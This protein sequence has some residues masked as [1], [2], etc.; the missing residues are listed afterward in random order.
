MREI[1]DDFD[2]ICVADGPRISLAL[3]CHMLVAQKTCPAAKYHVA[4]PKD[5]GFQHE[6][7]ERVITSLAT[8]IYEI[9]APT[10]IIDGKLYRL[11][12]KINAMKFYKASPAILID[13][14]LLF[15]R[16]LPANYAIRDVPAAVPEHGLHE[17][18]WE[19]LY[20]T[21]S[22]EMPQVKTLLGSGQISPPWLNAG[23]VATPN[24][25]KF[26]HIWRMAS[27]FVLGCDWVPEH[28][29]YLDQ[30]SLPLAIA[31]FSKSKTVNYDSILPNQF[32]DNIFY[33]HPDQS[34]ASNSFVIHH[35][36]R[37]GLLKRYVPRILSW[38]RDGNPVFDE[39][40]NGLSMFDDAPRA[41]T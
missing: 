31:M 34:Y 26:G 19:R 22:L 33:W 39:V 8:S 6:A 28:W 29:P 11:E 3:A 25:E 20:E 27:N 9:P 2:V 14:D 21:L 1:S 10:T 18:P 12:N 5:A 32:N 36:Y 7:A 40:L 38:V 16:P 35:H 23:L 17:Y 41:E 30:I 15:L 13:S 37:V 4:V 24:A